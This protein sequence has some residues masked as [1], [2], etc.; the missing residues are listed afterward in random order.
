[1]VGGGRNMGLL[2][3]SAFDSISGHGASRVEV[4][5]RNGRG[6]V[7]LH[8]AGLKHRRRGRETLQPRR[9]RVQPIASAG[10]AHGVVRA[11]VVLRTGVLGVAGG[12]HVLG[13]QVSVAVT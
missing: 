6:G 5:M 8:L 11:G 4:M 2:G 12:E 3:A 1:M 10:R 9:S 13:A 7:R